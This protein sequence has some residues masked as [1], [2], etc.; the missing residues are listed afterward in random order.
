MRKQLMTIAVALL[1]AG[2]LST[3][4]SN[5]DNDI[6]EQLPGYAGYKGIYAMTVQASK[7]KYPLSR[8]LSLDNDSIEPKWAATDEVSVFPQKWSLNAKGML[9]AADSDNG[10]TT[11]TGS[12]TKAPS[13]GDTLKLLF[14]RAVWDYTGQT[15]VLLSDDNSIEKKYD[16]ALADVAVKE[17]DGNM[18]VI[19]DNAN[20]QSQQAIVKFI[21]QDQNVD[22]INASSLTI[23]AASGK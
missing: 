5:E 22:P 15:G 9:I 11:L 13:V 7:N 19:T 10:L 4:C 20:F 3:S 21:L 16:Y 2:A 6:D 1:T 14:P 8:S 23:S 17:V 18:N 12:L